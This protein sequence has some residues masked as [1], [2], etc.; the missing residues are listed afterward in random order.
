M[1]NKKLIFNLQIR[2]LWNNCYLYLIFFVKINVTVHFDFLLEITVHFD[3]LLEINV[4]VHFDF[5]LE[6]NVT[7]H[8]DFL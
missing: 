7:V 2:F 6:I 3:F 4:T 8:F 1:F 5:L